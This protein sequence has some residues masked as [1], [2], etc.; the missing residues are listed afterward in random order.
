MSTYAA[1]SDECTLSLKLI[2]TRSALT[3]GVESQGTCLHGLGGSD[4]PRIQ[5]EVHRCLKARTRTTTYKFHDSCMQAFTPVTMQAC[6]C[7]LTGSCTACVLVLNGAHLTATNLGDSGYLIL[8]GQNV[9][10]KSAQQQHDFNF[11]YQMGH[12]GSNSDKPSDAQV[13]SF[14]SYRV[15]ACMPVACVSCGLCQLPKH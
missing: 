7:I 13:R 12:P 2:D 5:T 4:Q 15:Q 11:P 8:R 10:Y 1:G 3:S 14:A 9:V 6:C